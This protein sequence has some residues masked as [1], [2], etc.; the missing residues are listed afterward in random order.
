MEVFAGFAK[1]ANCNAGR[2]IDEI[3][4]P[5][6]LDNTLS[7]Y[8]WGDNG[9]SAERQKALRATRGT[10]RGR[11]PPRHFPFG[12]LSSVNLMTRSTVSASRFSLLTAGRSS[13]RAASLPCT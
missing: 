10:L 12:S 13:C 7:F 5:G 3:E 2:V 6:K 4:R 1:H 9:S 11:Q 8:I